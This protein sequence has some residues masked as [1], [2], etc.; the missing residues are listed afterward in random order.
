MATYYVAH[1]GQQ[2]GPYTVTEIEMQLASEKLL[3]H[4]YIYDDKLQD[5][6]LLW[7]MDLR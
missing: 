2:M 4:D 7:Q 6:V 1:N 5:W 3:W